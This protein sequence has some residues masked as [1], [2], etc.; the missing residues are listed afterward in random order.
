[1]IVLVVA[2]AISLVLM[3]QANSAKADAQHALTQANSAKAAAQRALTDSFFR[4]IG[5]SRSF[6]SLSLSSDERA[7][8]WDLAE[9][10][11]ENVQVRE[12]VIDRWFQTERAVLRGLNNNARGLRAASGLSLELRKRIMLRSKELADRLV[13][14]L[15]NPQQTDTSRLSSLAQ[16][17]AA[18]AA[19]MEPQE[20]ARLA[21]LLVTALE[22]PQWTDASRLSS[23]DDAVAAL[24]ARMEPQEA[25][26]LAARLVTV[27]EN[28]QWT[29]ASRLSSL[30]DAVA[31]LAARM[32][33]QEAAPLAA[34]LVTV[35]ENPQQTDASRLSS[36]GQ[37]VA[38]L[39]AR[40]EPAGGRAP[41][42]PQRTSAGHGA[43]KSPA[44]RCLP[45]VVSRPGSSGAGGQDG[46]RRRPRALLPAAH[47]Y[48]SR[49]W[50]I[51][52][53]PMPP[54][55]RLSARQ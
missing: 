2:T 51:P 26:P 25:A 12:T 10:A 32:E 23:L 46:A 19:S 53:R 30:D 38:A 36:L 41:C 37:A 39:A 21:A 49:C 20:A 34:R 50:K 54:T 48:W 42:R 35:L 24:A 45:P 44:D 15:E 14:A 28:P 33:P 43:G 16:V 7:A 8:L 31:A 52:S 6:G 3:F 4:T 13:T 17:V 29:D 47:K 18:L 27:L 40:M 22:N 1:M 9:L 11:S 5:T 55:C